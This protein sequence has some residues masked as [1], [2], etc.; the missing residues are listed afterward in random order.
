MQQQPSPEDQRNLILAAV[1]SIG[2]ILLWQI[3]Y[4]NPDLERQRAAQE[5]AR[6][7]AAEANVEPGAGGED[8]V[9]AD[10]AATPFG[11]ATLS[12]EAALER[13]PR[14]RIETEL[15][16]GTIALQGGLID[17]L[18]LKEHRESL[19]EDSPLVELLWPLGTPNAY[20]ARFGWF[21]GAVAAPSG[22]ELWAVEPGSPEVLTPEQPLRLIWDNG[23]GLLFRRTIALD[24]RYMFTITQSVENTTDAPV[25]LTAIAQLERLGTPEREGIWILHEGPIGVFDGAFREFDYED[26]A[27]GQ[28]LNAKSGAM[29]ERI[30]VANRGWLGFTDKYWMAALAPAGRQSFNA[31]FET[32]TGQGGQPIYRSRVFY[33]ER[34]VA[35]GES[36]EVTTRLFAGAKEIGVLRDYKYLI[37]GVAEPTSFLGKFSDFFLYGGPGDEGGSSRFTDAIDWGWFF[38]LTRPIFE[39]LSALNAATG[40][41]G[42][43]IILLTLIFKLILYPLAHKSFVSMSKLK[44]LQP[45]MQKIQE[46]H[47]EDRMQMQQAM[48]ELY[49]KEKVNPA[50]GCLPI[51]LQIPIFFSLYKVLYV[52]LEVRHAPFFGWIQDLSAPDPTSILNL[53]GL[54]PWDGLNDA[55]LFAIFAIGIWPVFMG[56][57]MWIQQML[58]PAPTDPVQAQIFN[59]LPLLFTFMLGTF[60]SGLV[61]YW[62]ANNVFTILQ[63]YSIMKSQGV[64]VDII[65]NMKRQLGLAPKETKS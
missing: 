45:E 13:S 19:D 27:D 52:T 65:G 60:A 47:K 64:E 4:V 23:E 56:V 8:A 49:K 41:M 30:E 15:L 31:V 63:Q 26:L 2:V 17:E 32:A 20:F 35:A 57:T 51:L 10:A 37:D 29:G 50:S 55:G 1:L 42:V 12:R 58:N 28:L 5:A 48:M 33:P 24:D 46:L 11:G 43:A 21:G 44:K 38:F 14:V 61:I 40:N 6:Q 16:E 62:T 53:F 18:K 7:A 36:L 9:A 25:D 34:T 39:L 54:M 3:F 22:A 59:M